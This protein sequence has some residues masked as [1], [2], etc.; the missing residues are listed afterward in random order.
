MNEPRFK[1]GD[2]VNYPFAGRFNLEIVLGPLAPGVRLLDS[3]GEESRKRLEISYV[4]RDPGDSDYILLVDE[5][6]LEPVERWERCV[7]EYRWA[8]DKRPIT[9]D[10][11]KK[12]SP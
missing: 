9:Y 11:E 7:G 10:M 8:D 1:H 4:I 3:D 5:P 6:N 2:R 12:V